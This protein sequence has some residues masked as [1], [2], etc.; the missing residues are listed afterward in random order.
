MPHAAPKV[1]IGMFAGKDEPSSAA[2]NRPAGQERGIL[3]QIEQPA[4]ICLTPVKN[5]AWILDRFLKCASMWADYI[6]IADQGSDDSSRDIARKYSKVRLVENSSSEYDEASRQQLLLNTA[7]QIDVP[8][9]RVLIALDADEVLSADWRSSAEWLELLKS[10]PGTVLHFEW[11]N[12]MPGFEKCWCPKFVPFGFIDNL[13]SHRG[14]RIHST[15]I[16]APPYAPKREFQT[17]K[18]LHYIYSDPHR[19]ESRL[20]WYQCWERV[21]NPSKRPIQLFRQYHYYDAPPV[22]QIRPFNEDWISVYEKNGIEMRSTQHETAFW[23]DRDVI[24]MFEFHGA[25]R[26]RKLDIWRTDWGELGRRLAI[27]VPNELLKDPRNRLERAVHRWLH[28]TQARCRDPW[29]R[30]I[31]MVLRLFGW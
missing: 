15:R 5:E 22:H 25:E 13:S 11:V 4:L 6:I 14:E 1:I 17:I 19:R 18:V 8:G 12:I 28:A 2:G 29:V 27:D 30:A 10:E 3:R 7:R 21:N 23:W 20:R 16:P 9:P 26:F 24:R 31:Q